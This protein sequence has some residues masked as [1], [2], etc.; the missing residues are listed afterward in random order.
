MALPNFENKEWKF[1]LLK[2]TNGKTEFEVEA[3]RRQFEKEFETEVMD[4]KELA[5]ARKQ[6]N[7]AM[8]IVEETVMANVE[9]D[10][11]NY[12]PSNK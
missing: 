4:E 9:K 3:D 8:S 11:I 7:I 10:Q 12:V 6:I 2:T 5:E 1:E